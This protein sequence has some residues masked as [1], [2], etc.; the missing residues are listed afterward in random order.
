MLSPFTVQWNINPDAFLLDP[1]H[2]RY[3]G[4]MFIAAF[5]AGTYIFW[6]IIK[7]E[8]LPK[9]LLIRL[10]NVVF[11]STIV[12]ARVGDCLFYFPEYYL[13]HPWQIF[14]PFVDGKFIGF[15]GLSSHGAAI[16]LLAGLYL[17]SRSIKLSYMW[18]LDRMV[19]A[20]A[21]A[22]FFIRIGNLMNSEIYGTVTS[23]PW[24][25]I[26]VQ[27]GE[28]LPRHP[29]QIYEA[30]AY[31]SIFF[32]LLY[33]LHLYLKWSKKLPSGILLGLFLVLTFTFRFFIEYIKAPQV[34]SEDDMIL[35]IGQALSLP[36]IFT[37]AVILMTAVMRSDLKTHPKENDINIT[38][39]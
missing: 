17:F 7:H 15:Q 9:S 24:G 1:F 2:I 27:K 23:L 12:G 20:I 3:Y 16:G 26:F 25:F 19:I 6:R 14:F 34:A 28:A 37:G 13:K 21:L 39:V 10:L 36:F 5:A 31:L 35:H 22:G 18:L 8:G 29:T 4:L 32:L 11:L 38:N 33:L 30:L